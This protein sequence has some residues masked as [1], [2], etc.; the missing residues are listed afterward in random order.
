MLRWLLFWLCWQTSLVFAVELTEPALGERIE[1]LPGASGTRLQTTLFRPAGA[2]PFPLVIIN[3]GKSTGPAS[4]EPRFRPL[5]AAQFFLASGYLVAVPMRSGFA[6]SSGRYLAT[7]CDPAAEGL[8]QAEDIQ[9]VLR[10]LVRRTDVDPRRVLLVGVSSGAWAT[11]AAGSRSLPGVQGL[12]NFAGGV[13]LE[14]CPRWQEALAVATA[15]YGRQ[16]RIP[17]LWLYGSND[18]FFAEPVWREM[19]RRYRS[20]GAPADMVA[21]GAF[22]HDAHALFTSRSGLDIWETPVTLFL[23][24]T[25]LP[26]ATRFPEYLPP[27]AMSAPA[28]T[29]FAALDNVSAIPFVNEAARATYR[30]F[31]N[32]PRPR[33]FA[34]AADGAWGAAWQGDDPLARALAICRRG[35]RQTCHLYAVDDK[36]VWRTGQR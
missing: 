32:K 17:S 11:L 22:E 9:A 12:V 10:T 21:Y 31:L 18:S 5:T 19:F 20:G 23:A 16:T 13:R 35:T 29:A 24:R 36:V 25:G 28:A 15:G 7:D 6:G 27:R 3:H 34:I 33:A 30:I 8:R 14:G 4:A 2:G 26:V 1:M